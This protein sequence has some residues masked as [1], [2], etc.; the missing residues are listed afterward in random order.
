M[1]R[2][3]DIG[4]VAD[5]VRHY[6]RI[7]PERPALLEGGFTLSWQALDEASSRLACALRRSGVREGDVVGWLGKNS[8]PFFELLYAAAKTG[9]TLLPLNWR[10][11]APEIAAVIDDAK[12]SIVF[13][14]GDLEALLSSSL[15]RCAEPG[16]PTAG[17]VR[18]PGSSMSACRG[19]IAGWSGPDQP[20][21]IRC[22]QGITIW[23]WQ[24]AQVTTP[25]CSRRS[26][27]SPTSKC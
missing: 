4:N 17:C 23:G 26:R 16:V 11:A 18:G 9:A 20:K 24:L 6:A 12:P 27:R 10:L 19:C 2:Y 5:I 14:E 3:A 15:G 25:G 8:I 7:T 13:A 21:R 1:W 22:T